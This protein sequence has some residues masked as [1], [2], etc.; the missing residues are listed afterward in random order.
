MDTAHQCIN[1]IDVLIFCDI[2]AS[3]PRDVF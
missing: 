1:Q 2:H 3:I